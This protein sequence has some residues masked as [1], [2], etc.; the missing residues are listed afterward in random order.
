NALGEL[1]ERYVVLHAAVPL[2]MVD[3]L[4]DYVRVI[5]DSHT[6]SATDRSSVRHSAGG[7]H[8]PLRANQGT[9]PRRRLGT[10]HAATSIGSR[11]GLKQRWWEKRSIERKDC[12]EH[13]R[14]RIQ[15]YL[16]AVTTG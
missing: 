10:D 13:E 15:S 9:I 8:D 11:N 6:Q 1:E 5:A 14:T 3:K 12:C 4:L 7:R 2:R 16:R